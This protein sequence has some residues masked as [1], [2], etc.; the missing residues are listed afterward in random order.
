MLNFSK[1]R[2]SSITGCF[3]ILEQIRY[4]EGWKLYDAHPHVQEGIHA[5]IKT[6][7][8]FWEGFMDSITI[9][10]DQSQT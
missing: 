8:G 10:L 6:E 4:I 2:L 1:Y 9:R 7:T 3:S 5:G